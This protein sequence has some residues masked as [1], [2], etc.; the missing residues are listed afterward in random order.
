MQPTA[1]RPTATWPKP[2]SR[3]ATAAIQPTECA[4][5]GPATAVAMRNMPAISTRVG[6]SERLITPISVKP[7]PAAR[8]RV[9]SCRKARKAAATA[10]Q[11][12]AA[13][14][15]SP[16]SNAV[17][18]TRSATLSST[19]PKSRAA[20]GHDRHGAVEVVDAPPRPAH[21]RQAI[22]ILIAHD[23]VRNGQIAT[24]MPSSVTAFGDNRSATSGLA[25]T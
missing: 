3:P 22:R 14:S 11:G 23:Q 1:H 13:A 19:Y 2:T 6:R 24:S 10:G 25:S 4:Q 15:A 18:P 9:Y 20:P 17:S 12:L 8:A 7:T 16:T 21:Q 5:T